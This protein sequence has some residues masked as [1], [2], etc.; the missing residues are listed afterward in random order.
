MSELE[1]EVGKI[2][3]KYLEEVIEYSNVIVGIEDKIYSAEVDIGRNYD[4]TIQH[5]DDINSNLSCEIEELKSEIESLKDMI[6]DLRE[7]L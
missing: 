3:T 1:I 2:F 5:A 4:Y 7:G 6:E